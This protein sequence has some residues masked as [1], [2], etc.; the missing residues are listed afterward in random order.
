[1]LLRLSISAK[2]AFDISFANAKK[3]CLITTEMVPLFP[4]H[5]FGA[6]RNYLQVLD[7]F[8]LSQGAQ[9][10]RDE[11]N[12]GGN[13]VVSEVLSYELI[14]RTFG[15]QFEYSEMQLQYWPPESKK[16][17]YSVTIDKQQ[18][19]GVSVTRA[20]HFLG[21]HLFTEWD[22]SML[23]RKKLHGVNLS[24]QNIVKKQKWERQILHIWTRSA[25]IAKHIGRAYKKLKSELRTN[26]IV[27]VTVAQECDFLF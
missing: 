17:D 9:V 20:M 4:V 24:S 5:N 8:H 13:S 12:A 11:P 25:S 21:D 1:M 18:R 19:V 15:A 26:T 23:L 14:G 2:R 3:P 27:I 7:K 22:A 6:S 10:I 16:T